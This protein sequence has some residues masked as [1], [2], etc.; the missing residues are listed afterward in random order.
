MVAVGQAKTYYGTFVYN[1]F[2]YLIDT[3]TSHDK[4]EYE[5]CGWSG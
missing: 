5:Q 3:I 2:I 1:N 4:V